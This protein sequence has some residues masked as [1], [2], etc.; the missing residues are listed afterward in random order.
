MQIQ[1]I[2]D[3]IDLGT[4]GIPVFQRGY[5]WNRDQVRGLMD[6]LYRK[7]PIGSLLVWVTATDQTNIRGD[8]SLAPGTI[9][10]LLDGQQRITTLYGIIRG[11][12]P[13]F[14]DGNSQSF[15]GLYFNL[16]DE[17]FEFYA[18]MKMKDNPLWINVT[19]LM[20]KGVGPFVQRLVLLPECQN[21]LN[22]YISRVSAIDQIKN[23]DL[24]IE[25]VAGGDKTIDVVVDIFNR[26]NSGGTKLSKGDLALAK[27]CA[28]WPEARD[29]MKV[30]LKKWKDAG[31][32]FRLDWLL[33][34]V[35]A[36]VTGKAEFS[37]LKDVTT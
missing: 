27:I 8:L 32:D 9:K 12:K 30:R 11:K 2:L 25:E 31:F 16:D 19:E 3:Q 17:T 29:E 35:N 20:Q 5:V 33:R 21:K 28:S 14:F 36:I 23:I 24:H 18:P 4:I 6:S 37:G 34:C 22:D 10:L 1:T 26:V 7:H 15:T 13:L